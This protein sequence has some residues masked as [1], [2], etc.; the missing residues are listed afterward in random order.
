MRR[1]EII[2]ALLLA[3][4][5]LLAAGF[6]FFTSSFFLTRIAVPWIARYTGCPV[7]VERAEYRP[8]SNRLILY[9]F[10]WGRADAPFLTVRRA[11]GTAQ[12]CNLGRGIVDFDDVELAGAELN[13][14]RDVSGRWCQKELGFDVPA[15]VVSAPAAVVP[16]A[17]NAVAAEP[18]AVTAPEPPVP[19]DAYSPVQVRVSRCRASP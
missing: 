13:I 10:R 7:S 4:V 2:F 1:R 16:S 19:A 18:A 3:A 15:E 8:F 12:W 6:F 17:V 5:F 9:G 14:C 11:R